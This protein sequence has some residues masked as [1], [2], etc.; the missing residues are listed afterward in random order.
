[1]LPAPLSPLRVVGLSAIRHA[2]STTSMHKPVTE[3]S[4][5][6]EKLD[7]RSLPARPL[8]NKEAE[9]LKTSFLWSTMRAFTAGVLPNL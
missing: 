4:N 5:N 2:P 7:S 1:M 9:L 8:N 6:K 3:K